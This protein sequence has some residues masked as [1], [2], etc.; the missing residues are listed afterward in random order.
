MGQQ[1]FFLDILRLKSSKKIILF[2][3]GPLKLVKRQ[4]VQHKKF[5]FWNYRAKIKILKLDTKNVLLDF[6]RLK[7]ERNDCDIS[8]QH[9]RIWVKSKLELKLPYLDILGSKFEKVL[10]YLKS[11]SSNLLKCKVSCKIKNH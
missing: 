9:S 4:V 3:I 5:H 8:S 10:S 1:F 7:I 2:G 6:F 11:A